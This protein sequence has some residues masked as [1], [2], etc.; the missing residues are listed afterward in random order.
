MQDLK[1][2]GNEKGNKWAESNVERKRPWDE[3][4][5]RP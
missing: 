1:A 5:M 4:Q 2:K 3:R